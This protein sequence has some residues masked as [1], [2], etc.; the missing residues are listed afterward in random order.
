V[1]RSS[2]PSCHTRP[3]DPHPDDLPWSDRRRPA[4]EVDDGHVPLAVR[5]LQHD[6]ISREADSAS[7]ESAGL[8]ESIGN[9]GELGSPGF[10]IRFTVV[11]EDDS[12]VGRRKH[13]LA[14][15]DESLGR[16]GGDEGP[17]ITA[18]GRA[19]S[20]VYRHEIDGVG[21]G[22]DV[23]AVA[24]YS[25]GGR[26]LDEAPSADREFQ[27]NRS[28]HGDQPKPSSQCSRLRRLPAPGSDE[29]PAK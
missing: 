5:H 21:R 25:P 29:I 17:P 12:A 6:V 14:E 19:S 18:P 16:L 8:A 27:N 7:S 20:L 10:M 1:A 28:W 11:D 13:R 2:S 24:R 15:S 3:P 4:P 22:H 9:Q 23:G 26:V